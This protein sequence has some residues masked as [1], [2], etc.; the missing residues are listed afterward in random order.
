[1]VQNTQPVAQQGTDNRIARL[2]NRVID[3]VA[4]NLGVS[5]AYK[6]KITPDKSLVADFKADSLDLAEIL[7]TLEDELGI[8][9]PAKD[10]E[11]KKDVTVG[12]LI[13][14][15]AQKMYPQQQ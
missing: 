9:I 5:S 1:M 3:A 12:E 10:F 8:E 11:E 15:A 6:K 13:Q 14:Y 7:N 4:W 2:Q